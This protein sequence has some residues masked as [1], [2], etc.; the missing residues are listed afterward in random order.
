MEK[1]PITVTPEVKRIIKAMV[2]QKLAECD[3]KGIDWALFFRTMQSEARRMQ[4]EGTNPQKSLII[5]FNRVFERIK[6]ES[7]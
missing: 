1:G 5:L 7:N 3:G 4:L 2:H 6:R